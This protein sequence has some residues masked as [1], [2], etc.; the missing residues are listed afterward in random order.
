MNYV[1]HFICVLAKIAMN[2]APVFIIGRFVW[3]RL[4]KIYEDR[5]YF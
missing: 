3:R 5:G 1:G 2:L 4:V